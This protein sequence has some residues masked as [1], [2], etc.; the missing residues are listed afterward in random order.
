LPI[1]GNGAQAV[2]FYLLAYSV[3]TLGAFGVL[4]MLQKQNRPATQV[5]DLAGLGSTNA[6]VAIMLAVFLLGLT[7]LPPTVGFWG[8][9]N[10]FLVAW[11]SGTFFMKLLAIGLAINAAIAAWYYLRLI[12]TAF[13][14]PPAMTFPAEG[15]ETSPILFGAMSVCALATIAFF[16]APGPLWALVGGM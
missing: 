9:F 4:V 3:M 16:F 5:S 10:L 7:G 1:D 14:D 8:K 12:K 13:L 11:A 2:L 15:R 6:G